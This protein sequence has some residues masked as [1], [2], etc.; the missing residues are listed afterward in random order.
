LKTE[1]IANVAVILAAVVLIGLNV[2]DRAIAR[3]DSHQASA[4]SLIGKTLPLP[5]SLSTGN[6]ITAVLFV[7]KNCHFCS[8][9][10]PFYLRMSA[11]RSGDSNAFRLL[12]VTPTGRETIAEG[13]QYFGEHGVPV[14]GIGE[15]QFGPLGIQGTP[16]LALLDPS[17]RVVKIWAGKVPDKTEE[18]IIGT[19][20][21]LCPECRGI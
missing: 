17:R 15:M 2:Y 3:V 1:N 20:R 21:Q 7:S 4:R 14:D 8:E 6:R 11:L 10:M 13:R 16:T 18:E 19:I 12:A 9:S 5:Q